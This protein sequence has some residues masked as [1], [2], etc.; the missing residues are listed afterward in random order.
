M[1][2][3][4]HACS[5]LL[6]S[7]FIT[8]ALHDFGYIDFDEPFK[9]L[10]HQGVI[11]GPDGMRMSKSR[12]NVISADPLIRKYGS[13]ALRLYLMF[14][15]DYTEGGPWTDGG[16][17]S[18]SKFMD[19][20]ERLVHEVEGETADAKAGALD[21]ELNYCIKHVTEDI[22]EF[23]FNTAVARCMELVNAMYKYRGETEYSPS[24]LKYCLQ[25]LV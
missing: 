3:A 19:R 18:C 17:V 15:F 12:G 1:G 2:G 7:R 25:T 20:V 23:R 22:P 24:Y 16:I 21:Y 6:Y 9:K 4:E 5:H 8:K 11:L 10:V 14:G 13:D